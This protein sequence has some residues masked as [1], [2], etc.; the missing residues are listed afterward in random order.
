MAVVFKVTNGRVCNILF[1]NAY[2][3]F[4]RSLAIDPRFASQ[5]QSV[6]LL[7]NGC[8]PLRPRVIKKIV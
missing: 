5:V 4:R 3:L 2:F 7:R 1:S 6:L 8:R